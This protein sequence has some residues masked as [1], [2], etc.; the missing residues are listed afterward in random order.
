MTQ[1]EDTF[2]GTMA[3]REQHRF[4]PARL[5]RYMEA[6]VEGFSGSLEVEQ[7][8][9]GQSC[10]T[11][12]LSAGGKSYVLRRK[13]PGKLLP[14][15]HAVDRECRVISALYDTPVPVAKS[16]AL[17]EDESIVGT[18]FY[19]MEWVEGRVFW[20]P[21]L[22]GLS[23]AERGAVY[24]AMN[25]V[26]AELHK[27]DYEAVGLGDFG[28]PGDYCARQI[29]RWTKQYKASETEKIEAMERLIEWLPENI[30][31]PDETTVVHG[32]YRLDN[33]IF[34]P[35]EPRV[36]AVLDW[37]LST[38]GHPLGDFTYQLMGW[39]LGGDL[40]RGVAGADL[41]ALGI[42]S[43]AEYVAAYCRR[44]GRDGIDNLEWY[45]AYNM[46]RL[47]GILQGIMGRALD[48]TAASEH[49]FE[50]GRRARPIA[51]A[52]WAQVEA[53]AG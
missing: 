17:S 41:E 2:A 14:S 36:L 27:V 50:Q 35:T 47:A 49:A 18:A 19:I 32:D 7:F 12:K 46:F 3:V 16:Y 33:M 22:P 31:G 25:E 23:K 51:E 9:G 15:A 42:P 39:R 52:A 37:E 1:L 29:S 6:H 53:L 4:D 43:E 5:Q 34:H 45:L 21:T 28:R 40:F 8:R 20:E 11:Y 48:G 10:P 38:L 13:P 44:T 24:D 30:P 26:L